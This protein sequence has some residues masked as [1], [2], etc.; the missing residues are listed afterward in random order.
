MEAVLGHS[1]SIRKHQGKYITEKYWERMEGVDK[2]DIY[3]I[4]IRYVSLQTYLEKEL[5]GY[6]QQWRGVKSKQLLHVQPY[7]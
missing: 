3:K 6:R 4:S 5:A 1:V 7:C 2:S